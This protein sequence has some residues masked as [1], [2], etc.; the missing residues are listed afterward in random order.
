MK[1]VL[2]AAVFGILIAIML[3]LNNYNSMKEKTIYC[4]DT[5]VTVKIK[6]SNDDLKAIEN[7]IIKYDEMFNAYDENSQ[8]SQVNNGKKEISDEMEEILTDCLSLA[9]ETDGAFDPTLKPISDLWGISE[10]KT[11]IPD[12]TD[13]EKALSNTGYEE[14]RL[15]DGKI[16]L[17]GRKLD[18]GGAVKGFVTEKIRTE[19]KKRGIKKAIIDLGGNIYVFNTKGDVKVGVQEPFSQRGNALFTIPVNDTAV[20]TSGPY[21]RYFEKNGKI[22]H[23]IFDRKTGYPVESE[24]SSVT[25]FGN[26]TKTDILSTAIL[27]MGKEKAIDLYKKRGGFE[28]AVVENKNIYATEG[29]YGKITVLNDEYRLFPIK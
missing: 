10:G 25:V 13:I 4:M 5:V 23:H 20:V 9:K 19:I 7:I 14:V 8:L 28:Y 24:I 11:E 26:G 18:L 15:S 16:N 2:M 21:E 22:Y 6:G 17:S 12:K 1:K 27:V 29:I 3:N